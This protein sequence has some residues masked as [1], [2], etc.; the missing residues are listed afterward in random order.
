MC[1]ITTEYYNEVTRNDSY[2]I[3]E[4]DKKSGILISYSKYLCKDINEKYDLSLNYSESDLKNYEKFKEFVNEL[5]KEG[6]YIFQ[7][8]RL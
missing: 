4:K 2:V 7:L 3:M 8:T 5:D 1:K 6:F